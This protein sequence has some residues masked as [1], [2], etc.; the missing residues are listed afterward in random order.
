MFTICISKQDT[1]MHKLVTITWLQ[2]FKFYYK[3]HASDCL[4][5]YFHCGYPT[6]NLIDSIG[7]K[8]NWLRGKIV[9]NI[10]TD[11]G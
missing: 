2:T 6:G 4:T 3:W 11:V 5:S 8:E 7:V 10:I 9:Y 1:H